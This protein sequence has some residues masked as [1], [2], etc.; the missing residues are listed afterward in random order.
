MSIATLALEIAKQEVVDLMLGHGLQQL[1]PAD[2]DHIR[3]W[4]GRFEATSTTPPGLVRVEIPGHVDAFRADLEGTPAY[5]TSGEPNSPGF[6]AFTTT[7]IASHYQ[8]PLYV[9]S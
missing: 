3:G 6:C 7:S 5:C 2:I 4:A 8:W 1:D 9:D